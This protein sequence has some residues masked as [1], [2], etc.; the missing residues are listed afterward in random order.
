MADQP[1]SQSGG[2]KKPQPLVG[3]RSPI[4]TRSRTRTLAHCDSYPSTHN[5]IALDAEQPSA[6]PPSQQQPQQQLDQPPSSALKRNLDS[7]D[8]PQQHKKLKSHFRPCSKGT[9]F[10][11]VLSFTCCFSWDFAMPCMR[12]RVLLPATTATFDGARCKDGP[13]LT[14]F[15]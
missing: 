6:Q 11:H 9:P 15:N 7:D 1:N 5:G 8:A 2:S 12:L 3:T 10:L 4:Q 14:T 13:V